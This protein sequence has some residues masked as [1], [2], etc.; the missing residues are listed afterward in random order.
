MLKIESGDKAIKSSEWKHSLLIA[1]DPDPYKLVDMAVPKAAAYSGGAKPLNQ[2]VIPQSLDLFGWCSWDAFYSSVSGRKIYDAVESL[3]GGGAPP[4]F[5]IID[6]GWQQT[7]IE[8]ECTS[9]HYD[10]A[11]PNEFVKRRHSHGHREAF[12]EVESR[13][14]SS[15][16][17]G[18]PTGSTAGATFEEVKAAKDHQTSALTFHSLAHEHQQN[19]SN[20][21]ISLGFRSCTKQNFLK[22]VDAFTGSLFGVIQTIFLFIYERLIDPANHDSWPFHL[23]SVL[24]MGPLKGQLLGFLGDQTNFTRRLRS[25]TANYKFILPSDESH[26]KANTNLS[27]LKHVVKH[28]KKELS[29]EHVFCWHGLS[30]YWSGVSVGS[31][32]MIKY[33]PHVTY[34]SPP[35]TILVVEPSMNWNPA[36]LAGIGAIYDPFHLYNDMHSY[37]SSCGVSGVKVDCQSGVLLLGSVAGGAAAVANRYHDALEASVARY[38]QGNH[39]INCMCHSIENIY[40]WK[41]TA[42]ARSSDDFYPLDSASHLPH[43]VACAYNGF[44]LSPLVIPDFDMFQSNHP[45]SETHAIARAV[46]GGPIYVSDAPGNHDFEI[47]K[48]LVLSDGSILRPNRPCRPTIDCLFSDVTQDGESLLKIWSMNSFGAVIGAF[49]L[50]GYSWNRVK[51]KFWQHGPP[52]STKI[53]SHITPEDIPPFRSSKCTKYV[54]FSCGNGRNVWRLLQNKH[55]TQ[56]IEL[57]T[58]EALAVSLAPIYQIGS[59]NFSAIGLINM[60][61]AGGAILSIEYEGLNGD[62]VSVLDAS[63]PSLPITRPII[64]LSIKGNG[65]FSAY[66]DQRPKMCCVDGEEAHF[67]WKDCP[68]RLDISV[69][70][71]PSCLAS[72]VRHTLTLKF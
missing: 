71:P 14:I 17:D 49:N 34:A 1:V 4:K 61:N 42:I 18:I 68:G 44:F 10:N 41:D 62:M 54:F 50:Q 21:P 19:N 47:L 36:V 26:S 35:D 66:C 33:S 53:K 70:E 16:L 13:M 72:T 3:R 43:I 59:L 29:V 58:G 63:T 31:E 20:T 32:E 46:S 52:V 5:V 6:D 64:K 60:Y 67:T 69:S 11:L 28:L 7:E 24:A 38:F 23:F 37:L 22:V 12:I 48:K 25:V 15:V 30:A 57:S 51:R 55:S 8:E 65:L 56:G 27:G 40:R 39:V 9:L 45:M 2:K